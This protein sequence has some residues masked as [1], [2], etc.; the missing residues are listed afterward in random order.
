MGIKD[1]APF[2]RSTCPHIYKPVHL[3]AFAGKKLAV[4]TSLYLCKYL[5]A[6]GE[7]RW[8]DNIISMICTLKKNRVHCVFVLD[9]KPPPEKETKARV[10]RRART[11]KIREQAEELDYVV[12]AIYDNIDKDDHNFPE[13]ERVMSFCKHIIENNSDLAL[14]TVSSIEDIKD[15]MDLLEKKLTTLK[16]QSL[17]IRKEHIDLL[18]KVLD[19]FGVPVLQAD[20]EAEALCSYLAVRGMVDGVLTEDTDVMVYGTPVFLS[21]FD[22]RTASCQMIEH[23]EILEALEFTKKQFVEFCI[24][25]GTDYNERIPKVGPKTAF[26]LLKQHGS[27]KNIAKTGKN[28]KILNHKRGR[29]L[30]K[31]PKV[32]NKI[33]PKTRQLKRTDLAV[34]LAQ[35]NCAVSI[36]YINQLWKPPEII[37]ED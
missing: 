18:K 10:E 17:S 29:E 14:L 15:N 8:I 30:F 5:F 7:D 9:G 1:L 3:S 4:D 13:Y 12:N 36:N 22:S 26:K 27:I 31:V 6:R 34:L 25:C 24:M 37:F 20:G 28:V 23:P 21:K 11:A 33:V 19:C 32:V 16:K 2:L 35:N